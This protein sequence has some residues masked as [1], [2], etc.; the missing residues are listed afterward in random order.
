MGYPS[1]IEPLQGGGR[2]E[3]DLSCFCYAQNIFG[4][5]LRVKG[6]KVQ[7]S[8]PAIFHFNEHSDVSEKL[9]GCYI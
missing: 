4:V 5:Y 7:L 3:K 8:C 9:K 6:K 2:R 1:V